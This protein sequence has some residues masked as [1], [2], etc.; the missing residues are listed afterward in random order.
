TH[1]DVRVAGGR[2]TAKAG[3]AI[4]TNGTVSLS[5]GFVFAYRQNAHEVIQYGGLDVPSWSTAIVV[6]WNQGSKLYP[7]G[8]FESANP[9]LDVA[10]N[11]TYRN[12]FWHNS[13]NEGGGIYYEHYPTRG[14]FPLAHVSVYSDYGLI[15]DARTLQLLRADTGEPF[16]SGQYVQW[17]IQN[18]IGQGPTL[19]L[20]GFSWATSAGAALTVIGDS[21]HKPFIQLNGE[22]VFESTE[23]AGTG[24]NATGNSLTIV[25][26]GTLI[27]RGSGA[28]GVGLN[29]NE[30]NLGIRER[31]TFIAQGW[32]RAVDWVGFDYDGSTVI[33]PFALYYRWAYSQRFEGIGTPEER[34]PAL[35]SPIGYWDE[36][37][38]TV[39]QFEFWRTDRFVEL[40][41]LDPIRLESAVQIGGAEGLSD[42]TAIVLTF[43][44]PV[45]GLTAADITIT[46][47]AYATPDA[48]VFGIDNMWTIV[49]DAVY[50]NNADALV[51][52]SHFGRF[53]INPNTAAAVVYKA[54]GDIQTFMLT[55][56]AQPP[57]GGD[58]SMSS[59]FNQTP[60][61]QFFLAGTYIEVIAEASSGFA[62][63][64][65]AIEGAVLEGDPRALLASFDM[66]QGNVVLTANFASIS[67]G[68]DDSGDFRGGAGNVAGP[69]PAGEGAGET[70]RGQICVDGC[71]EDCVDYCVTYVAMRAAGNSDVSHLLNTQRHRPFIQGIGY[72]LFA[73]GRDMTRAEVA[74]M[75]FNL[76]I[77][78]DVEI[79]R[80]F[81]D[82][83][84]RAWHERA[85]HTLASLGILEGYPDGSFRPEEPVTRAQF[86]TIAVR[87]AY[88][89]P[90]DV[91]PSPFHDLSEDH[92]AYRHIRVALQFGWIAGYGDGSFRPDV[93]LSRAEAVAI[94]TRMLG[95]IPD[96]Q[97]I[98][99]HPELPQF[100]DVPATHW[101]F[102]YIMEA[103]IPHAYHIGE[104]EEDWI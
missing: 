48:V 96:R 58:T 6:S 70:I 4:R 71:Y 62:F 72:N 104:G 54:A 42:S 81:P 88:S 47:A 27:A 37:F 91:V 79:T 31:T 85:V 59:R 101:A 23:M 90:E 102:Y 61:F 69:P 49:L 29:L 98:D 12:F 89:L 77:E 9:D 65:W 14:F 78:Q 10:Y 75:F 43:S 41:A 86:V 55:V 16:M 30:H 26:G 46:G 73:P 82:E 50:A 53:Y 57:E 68:G 2:V 3:Y 99:A 95:R 83:V 21:T 15:F 45:S 56:R 103:Y 24:I 19:I 8:S 97:Y 100:D 25:G 64:G 40:Q 84:S 5:G 18:I 38:S 7:E 17:N 39:S 20:N 67:G 63:V 87:F 51:S 32:G 28:A 22:S 52:V 80:H 60:Q 11:G 92:W 36:G 94:V 33:N 76:L 35:D 93:H 44:D 1:A 74:Q 66:P 13:P 34:R